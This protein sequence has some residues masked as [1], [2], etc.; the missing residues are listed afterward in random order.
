MQ[1]ADV[2]LGLLRERGK[3][4]LPLERVYRQLFNRDLYLKA[5]GKIYRNQGSTTRG[6]TDDTVDGMSLE[7][8][9]EII[10]ALRYERWQWLPAKRIYIPKRN[11]KRR[12]LGLPVWTDKLLGEVVRMML[13][14]YYDVQ[15]SDHSHGFREERGCHTALREMYYHWAGATWV[16]EGD[17]SDCFGSLDHEL[18]LT[19]LSENIH[20][21]RF[22]KLI[23]KLLDA[24]YLEDWRY[25]QT[26]SGVPQG[27][28][29]SPI[30]SNILLDK[31][32]SFV[33]TVLIPQYT[34]G[35]KRRRNDAYDRLA[36]RVCRLRKQGQK[37]AARKIK[38]QMQ[39]LPS[40]DTRD[41]DY[42]RLRYI[43]YA[44]DFGLA[45]IGPKSE[46]EEIKGRLTFFLREELKLTL[47][48]EKTL[49]T[50]AR[51]GAAKFLGYE[52]TTLHSDVKQTK[53]KNGQKKRNINGRVGL[54]IPHKVLTEK[55]NR[56]R[57]GGK[58]THRAE[59][60][61][62]SDYTI[63]AT[64]QLEYRGIVEYYRL[65]YNLHTLQLLKWIMETSLT[66]TLASKHKI[67]VKKVYKKYQ[68]ELEV[69]G[70][71]YKVLQA[72]VLRE[73][74]KPLVAT[75][76]G[77]PLTWDIQATIQDR[78]GPQWNRQSELEKRLLAQT[79][80]ICGATRVTT[81]IEVH[82]IRALKDLQKYDGREKPLWVKV[83]AARCRKTLV[84]CRSCHDDVHAGRPLKQKVSRS[85]TGST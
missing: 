60:L 77:I 58:A 84:L 51:N 5:Y 75:W 28:I 33:S 32:D 82:H 12:P 63:I 29:A 50:H 23:S 21:G 2:Y 1:S 38:A 48:D 44:D 45:F 13:N 43:R 67:S 17:I 7:K 61:N 15:F 47:S 79:C 62:E 9:D 30:L 46:A 83:M 4:G 53:A 41:P 35:E 36:G 34:R 68:T 8:I 49:I 11:G 73:G 25:N 26:L 18:L 37:E 24:G 70:R 6:V 80:E 10:E 85:R 76:G 74:K 72:T 71:K 65:A 3:R 42:R 56:Y 55:C 39:K 57:K 59:L 40:L 19:T 16:I 54:R 14:A 78:P 22:I 27:S 81:Q 52:I 20:D 64:Y 69:E 66:K 31:L